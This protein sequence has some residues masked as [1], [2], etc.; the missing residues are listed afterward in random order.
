MSIPVRSNDSSGIYKYPKKRKMSTIGIISFIILALFMSGIPTK[1]Y[2][3]I[4]VYRHEKIKNYLQQREQ[5]FSSSD[6]EFKQL[7]KKVYQLNSTNIS[8]LA[9]DIQQAKIVIFNNYQSVSNLKPPRAFKD[10]HDETLQWFL[11]KNSAIDY[12]ETSAISSSYQPN[13]FRIY[14]DKINETLS[15]I[16]PKFIQGLQ[17]EKLEYQIN[18][19]GSI[20]YWIKTNVPEEKTSRIK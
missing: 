15:N 16:N 20:T 17:K 7:I 4:T 3:D 8:S 2:N 1:I 10:L 14:I 11:E 18:S 9:P 19:D 13:T 6:L 12:L 5:F